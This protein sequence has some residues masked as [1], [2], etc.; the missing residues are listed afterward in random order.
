MRDILVSKAAPADAALLAA[1]HEASF[2]G[3]RPWGPEA[4]A[5][6][7]NDPCTLCLIGIECQ[8]TPV[9]LLIARQATD[10]AELLTIGTLPAYRRRGIGRLLLQHAV[11]ALTA[12]GTKKLFLEVDENNEAA[13]ALY[14]VLGAT[15]V[16]HRPGYYEN[17]ADA[18]IFSLALSGSRSDDAKNCS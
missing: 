14:R 18:L 6:F 17:G 12:R 16:G 1:L 3:T 15:Q 2:R 9:G 8:E 4:M 11:G 5:S 7:L 10:E 13:R